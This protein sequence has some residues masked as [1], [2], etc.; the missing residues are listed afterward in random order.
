MTPI[1]EDEIVTEENYINQNWKLQRKRKNK[2]GVGTFKSDKQKQAKQNS[3]KN[4]IEYAAG[5]EVTGLEHK[6]IVITGDFYRNQ[7]LM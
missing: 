6:H 4:F 3:V 1:S 2:A 7:I 5:N